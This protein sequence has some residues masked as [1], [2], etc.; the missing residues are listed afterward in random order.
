MVKREELDQLIKKATEGDEKAI[1]QV[2]EYYRQPIYNLIRRLVKDVAEAEDLTT[3]VFM[4]LIVGLRKYSERGA[5]NTW[6]FTITRN[7]VVDYLRKKNA[8]KRRQITVSLDKKLD[9]EEDY[10]L[11][12]VLPSKS[13]DPE[14][15]AVRNDIVRLVK[16]IINELPEPYRL[17]VEL[18]Y[19]RGM[20]HAE[21]SQT[22]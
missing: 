15:V 12:D 18:R 16:T 5:F 8:L 19:L 6:V 11:L 14:S 17:V 4:K 21:I 20:S 7:V 1:V 10:S 13:E 9:P 3:E 22:L 2:L